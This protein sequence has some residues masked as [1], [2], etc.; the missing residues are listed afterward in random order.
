VDDGDDLKTVSSA[1][2]EPQVVMSDMEEAVTN[3]MDEDEQAR[4]RSPNTFRLV[5]FSFRFVRPPPCPS[6]SNSFRPKVLSNQLEE[7]NNGK[8]NDTLPAPLMP[9]CAV[10]VLA[11]AASASTTPLVP[12]SQWK[13]GLR[14]KSSIQ[15][16]VVVTICKGGQHV[17]SW[18]RALVRPSLRK[19]FW[20]RTDL[21]HSD[22]SRSNYSLIGSR[23]KDPNLFSA[24]NV[25]GGR[26]VPKHV[27]NVLAALANRDYTDSW[28]LTGGAQGA[29]KK[30]AGA[31]K[32]PASA[33]ES[34]GSDNEV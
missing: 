19:R 26:D 32:R 33:M 1:N 2:T 25:F 27:R 6:E 17:A 34:A 14:H 28:I 9:P 21:D 16:S 24:K 22:E 15:L 29:M 5:S 18:R 31:M 7:L 10:A 13:D 20:P 12:T 11:E 30:P 3:I 23:P 8:G 4:D